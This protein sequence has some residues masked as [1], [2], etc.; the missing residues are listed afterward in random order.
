MSIRLKR[1]QNGGRHVYIK[2][3]VGVIQNV[4]HLKLMKNIQLFVIH[5]VTSCEF[6]Q[7]AAD[8]GKYAFQCVLYIKLTAYDSSGVIKTSQVKNNTDLLE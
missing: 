4:Y 6:T 5:N 3:S 2:F 1:F 8:F 7:H